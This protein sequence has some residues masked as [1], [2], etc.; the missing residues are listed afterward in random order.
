MFQNFIPL[1]HCRFYRLA[2]AYAPADIAVS[3]I[4]LGESALLD[5]AA[6]ERI[7]R[8]LGLNSLI[9]AFS[10][11]AARRNG[12]RCQLYPGRPGRPYPILTRQ[13][14]SYIVMG[15]VNAELG[16]FSLSCP[17]TVKRRVDAQPNSLR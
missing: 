11:P 13:D 14:G 5:D 16:N 6:A 8:F 4:P 9:C 7:E 2:D 12:R 15:E 1:P 3:G 10:H 17:R